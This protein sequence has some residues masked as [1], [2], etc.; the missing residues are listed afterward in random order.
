MNTAVILLEAA[1]SDAARND[2]QMSRP[3]G[4][5][6]V[7]YAWRGKLPLVAPGW[8]VRLAAARIPTGDGYGFKVGGPWLGRA[9]TGACVGRVGGFCM[10]PVGVEFG[11]G[12]S[13]ASI[14]VAQPG[15]VCKETSRVTL[16]EIPMLQDLTVILSLSNKAWLRSISPLL[17]WN[18]LVSGLNVR[19]GVDTVSW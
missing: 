18:G 17:Y 7:K 5:I 19:V 13:M 3:W 4:R 6:L 16:S 10:G 12:P 1:F 14:G 9:M 15:V 8:L 11:V 2:R